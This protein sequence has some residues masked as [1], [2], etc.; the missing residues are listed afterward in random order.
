MRKRLEDKKSGEILNQA[1]ADKFSQ[2][3]QIGNG[4]AH[5]EKNSLL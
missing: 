1:E 5:G 3:G 4:E 2:K